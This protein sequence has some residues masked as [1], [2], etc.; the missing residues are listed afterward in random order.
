MTTAGDATGGVPAMTAPRDAAGAAAA[1]PGGPAPSRRA[2]IE[3]LLLGLA[4]VSYT[5]L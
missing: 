3:G 5:H 4:A 1:S 2:R